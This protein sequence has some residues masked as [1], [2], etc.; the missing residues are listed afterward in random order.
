[1]C[2]VCLRTSGKPSHKGKCHSF[3]IGHACACG[4]D[5]CG[6]PSARIPGKFSQPAN[7]LGT[8]STSLEPAKSLEVQVHHL[9]NLGGWHDV[10]SMCIGYLPAHS[11]NACKGPSHLLQQCKTACEDHLAPVEY[12][13]VWPA[14]RE[15]RGNANLLCIIPVLSDARST[16]L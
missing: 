11:C 3:G 13:F 8:S 15:E 1:M 4:V 5:A 12:W 9:I 6:V 14:Q 2:S 7:A 16:Q 10:I